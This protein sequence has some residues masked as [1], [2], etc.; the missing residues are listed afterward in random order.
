MRSIR[1][2]LRLS[3]ILMVI[4][5]GLLTLVILLPIR[6]R[7]LT[8]KVF[9]FAKKAILKIVGI[10]V[11]GP[12]F[13]AIPE[14]LIVAN[15]RSYLD[16]LFV[17]TAEPLTIVAKRE[18]KSWPLIGWAAMALGTIWVKRENKGSR[19]AVRQSIVRAIKKGN[20]VVLFPEGTSWEGPLMLPVKPAM[21]YEAAHHGY[22]IYQWSLHF[23]TAKTAF[24]V[25]INFLSHLWAISLEKEVNAYI[26]VRTEPIR[27][28]DG[29]AILE[30]AQRWWNQSLSKLSEEHPARDTGYW[31][32]D[33]L[34]SSTDLV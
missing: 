8:N 22:P 33:R 27:G 25:G 1:A 24:P 2:V 20:R 14:G 7:A 16:I 17:P 32:D 9:L 26:D 5:T 4:I 30:D 34:Y 6:S 19:N 11:H 23:D 21:F 18:V 29:D 31:P 15:H 28:T 12:S 3:G 10:R 13:D